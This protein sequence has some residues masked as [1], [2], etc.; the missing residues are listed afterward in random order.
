[1]NELADRLARA[2]TLAGPMPL[3]Q[4][5][6]AANADY[7]AH[8]DAIGG[9]FITA[10]EVSQMFGELIGV[11]LADVW[12]RAGQPDCHYVELGPGDRKS[13]RLNS[14]HI[15]PSRMPSSA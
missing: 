4:F 14:S 5:M 3:S 1:M 6:A 7:Y 9:D 12:D 2:I 11:A 8:R 10:P 15:T 13:T